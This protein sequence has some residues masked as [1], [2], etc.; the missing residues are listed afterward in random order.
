M[1]PVTLIYAYYDN[2]NML[3]R[4]LQEW[5]QYDDEHKFYL[6]VI[7]VDDGSPNK[8]ALP[9]IREIGVPF[10]LQLYRVRNDRAWNQDG[11]RNLG[12]LKCDTEWAL[13]TDMDHM[14]PG[15]QVQALLEFEGKAGEYYM[16]GQYLTHSINLHRPH[17]NTYLMS[18][19]D[20]WAAGGYDED[21]CGYYGSDGNFRRCMIGAGLKEV[22]APAFHLVVYRSSDIADA[23]TK[24]LGRKHSEL[25]VKNNKRLRQKLQKKPYKAK[26]HIRFEYDRLI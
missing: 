24:G 18:C 3:R 1:K 15:H 26:N 21:F 13:M 11:C 19:R 8:P 14:L 4:Q 7:I 23:N 9:V 6:R 25:W 16:P 12:M 2:A 17:P 20:F 10:T 22:Y 5:M